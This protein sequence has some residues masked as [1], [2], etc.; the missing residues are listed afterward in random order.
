M[1]ISEFGSYHNNRE[2]DRKWRLK[3]KKIFSR[4]IVGNPKWNTYST[5]SNAWDK[6]FHWKYGI[7]NNAFMTGMTSTYNSFY[8]DRSYTV[9]YAK[10]PE[11]RLEDCSDFIRLNIGDGAF[12]HDL[13][14]NRVISELYSYH[15]NYHQDRIFYIKECSLV[16]ALPTKK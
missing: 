13:P 4:G 7:V 2:E 1:K 16:S 5:G 6:E 9:Y 15:D 14:G 12:T 8:D 10:S 3:C 11:W